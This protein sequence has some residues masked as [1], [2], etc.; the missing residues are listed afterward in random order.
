MKIMKKSFGAAF[1]GALTLSFGLS[2]IACGDDSSSNKGKENS[3]SG[4]EEVESKEELPHCTKSHYGEVVYV[5]ELDSAFECT[6]EGWKAADS[7]AIE[8]AIEKNESSA[9]KDDAKSS[10]SKAK[11]SSSVKVSAEDTTKVEVVKI[12]S[13]KL[14]GFAQKGPFLS[15]SSVTVYGLDSA[16]SRTQTKFTGKVA[17]DSGAFSVPGIVLNSQFAEVEVAGF[18]KNAVTGKNSN[19]TKTKL[20]ALV[21]L[22]EGNKVK[23]NVNIF[24][25]FEKSRALALV[26]GKFNI[27]AAK[28]RASREIVSV[29]GKDYS[30]K[31]IDSS[32]VTSATGISLSDTGVVGR[33]L[34]AAGVMMTANLSVSKSSALIASVSEDIAENGTWDDS[35][36]RATVADNL[37]AQDSVD[38]FEGIRKNLKEMKLGPAVPDFEDN[39]RYF[40]YEE[41]GL[42]KC[43]DS[44]E[45]N[46]TLRKVSNKQSDYYGAGFVCTSRRWHKSTALDAELGLCT[47]KMEGE[48][49]VS[50]LEKN[51]KYFTCKN[52]SWTEISSTQYELKS[53]TESREME[54]KKVGK[55]YFVCSSNQWKDISALEYELKLCT[56]KRD[57]EFVESSAKKYYKCSAESWDE[58]SSTEFELK[59]CTES[60]ENNMVKAKVDGKTYVCSG[61]EWRKASDV[62]LELNLVCVDSLKKDTLQGSTKNYYT[63]DGSEWKLVPSPYGKL[64][65]CDEGAFEKG[66]KGVV[67]DTM[68]VCLKDG[69]V[70]TKD[71]NF[72]EVGKV[73][74]ESLEFTVDKNFACVKSSE[75][76]VWRSASDAEIAT[77][78]VCNEGSL[79][80]VIGEY[81]C[82]QGESGYEWTSASVGEIATGTVCSKDYEKPYQ[83]VKGYVCGQT[84][85]GGDWNWRSV[86]EAE[87]K[88]QM[89]CS[90][91]IV[92]TL[93]DSYKCAVSSSTNGHYDGNDFYGWTSASEAE[94]ATGA[95][96]TKDY[97][98]PYQIV[99]EY[100]C[101]QSYAGSDWSWR[102][103]DAVEKK[104]LQVCK[105]EIKNTVKDSY[106][107]V[108][109]T[110]SNSHYSG[111]STYY[112]W[113]NAS[114]AEIATGKIY[115]TAYEMLNGY[116]CADDYG[117]KNFAWRETS[118]GEIA[119][120]RV[121]G[122]NTGYTNCTVK[123]DSTVYKGYTCV[124]YGKKN[125][126]GYYE[127]YW[128][129]YEST[130]GEKYFGKMCTPT[131]KKENGG[132]YT[133]KDT[134]LL[135]QC[136]SG[137][138]KVEAIKG[139]N[140]TDSRKVAATGN[141]IK[142]NDTLVA[143]M[144]WMT[145][146]LRYDNGSTIEQDENT[147]CGGSDTYGSTP[148][149]DNYGRLYSYAAAINACPDDWHLPKKLE[150]DRIKKAVGTNISKFNPQYAGYRNGSGK[151]VETDAVDYYWTATAVSTSDANAAV[152]TKSNSSFA[153]S[154]K[155]KDYGF[156]VRCIHDYGVIE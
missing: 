6:S 2:L 67:N 146:N 145:Q 71:S 99:N 11:S 147:W 153:V 70:S 24:T 54:Y 152:F 9:S 60:L 74:D 29:F 66:A 144:V 27:P 122:C 109:G 1:M 21:D 136:N 118:A 87:K 148:S 130:E 4:L 56:K 36:T 13:V 39:L 84:K 43:T 141:T 96:C 155:D 83:V 73:C 91:K 81:L 98:K 106:K 62:E 156:A 44:L 126:S 86:D 32:S 19:G 77:D 92:N 82:S 140:F 49:K 114:A 23:A 46:A 7:S 93:K 150:M 97:D 121:C 128:G 101:G 40:W 3:S 55:E 75:D 20:T 61:K 103:A 79:S 135:Y 151:F 57:G 52:G 10:S 85:N 65:L 100:V 42:G 116:T 102:S 110:S 68:W 149:C 104:T 78:S 25:E 64:G 111:T 154:S 90:S 50:K 16:Y 88:L 18:F 133:K 35:T 48:F 115:C 89:V 28:S 12:D 94:I 120:G 14:L 47:S 53:C 139:D 51:E 17:G 31:K 8:E 138:N 137:W 76:Y 125:S 72:Y 69:W 127:Y 38:G 59:N 34:Y 63:C 15:G 58:V 105:A 95:V 142:Y 117:K 113:A 107:C 80:A 22:S 5:T 33:A 108:E 132:Y 124:K 112:K 143:G 45:A 26:K 119:T 134:S 30:G 129:W 41:F 131:M 123:S 37:C